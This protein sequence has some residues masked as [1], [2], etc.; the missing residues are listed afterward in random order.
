MQGY[1]PN[2]QQYQPTQDHA[3]TSMRKEFRPNFGL[4]F[5]NLSKRCKRDLRSSSCL[6]SFTLPQGDRLAIGI[7]PWG[8]VIMAERLASIFGTEKDKYV[9]I[10]LLFIFRCWTNIQNRVN[11]PF[12]FKIGACRHGDRCSR[13]HNK[14]SLS[15]TLLLH[16]IH[17]WWCRYTPLSIICW[18]HPF[19]WLF[20]GNTHNNCS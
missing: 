6:L 15:Q 8:T 20:W 18:S 11:C 4:D 7:Q 10:F 3:K 17:T 19:V 2:P 9:R 1:W 16:S 12:Y 13:L 14:P 5:R